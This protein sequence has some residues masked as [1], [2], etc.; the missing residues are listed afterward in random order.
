L[1]IIAKPLRI[2]GEFTNSYGECGLIY[3]YTPGGFGTSI[4]MALAGGV[5]LAPNPPPPACTFVEASG[6]A[7]N[8]IPPSDASFFDTIN[9]NVQQEP[10]DSYHTELAGQLASIGIVKGKPFAPDDRMRKILSDAAAVGNA[11]DVH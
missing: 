1:F 11:T 3:P 10:A 2:S 7:F 5:R 4:A 9:A 6:K 8:T